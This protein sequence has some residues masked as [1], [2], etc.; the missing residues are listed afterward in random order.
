[1]PRRRTRRCRP[2]R[3]GA[4]DPGVGGATA[5]AAGT[6]TGTGTGT[7]AGEA[8]TRFT[9]TLDAH[10]ARRGEILA[11]RGADPPDLVARP[12]TPADTG[13]GVQVG[14]LPVVVEDREDLDRTVRGAD[15]VRDHRRELGRLARPDRHGPARPGA[16]GPSRTAR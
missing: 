2:E 3:A 4:G 9:T 15:G 10:R 5:T 1:M 12:V 8:Q 13:G 11:R 7:G 16:A 14:P 6:A